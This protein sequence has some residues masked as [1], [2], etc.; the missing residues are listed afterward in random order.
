MP[1]SFSKEFPKL[2]LLCFELIT[3]QYSVCNTDEKT[4]TIKNKMKNKI[5]VIISLFALLSCAEAPDNSI[6]EINAAGDAGQTSAVYSVLFGGTQVGS[7]T[8]TT[9]GNQLSIDYGFEN[10]G[11]GASSVEQLTLSETGFPIEWQINGKTTF[12]NNVD[13]YFALNGDS[14]KWRSAAGSGEAENAANQMY[15]AQNGSPY[16]AYLYVNALIQSPEGEVAALPA[17]TIR[18]SDVADFTFENEDGNRP[19]RV[20]AL[21]GIDLDPTYLALDQNDDLMALLSPRFSMIL[22]G[23]EE[24]DAKLRELATNL[25][26]SRFKEI[27]E[28][29]THNFDA[30]IRI[31]NVRLFDPESLS[32]TS[33]K[34]V[35]VENERIIEVA[36][37]MIEPNE[38]EIIIDGAGGTLV[39]G[40]YEMH[41][42]MSDNDA[43]LNVLAGVTSVRDTGNE[44][45][46][47]GKLVENIESG[48]L[49]GPR[50]T[51]SGFIEGRSDFS[52]ATG[53]I[54]TTQEEA[55]E[56]VKMYASMEGY[57][58]IKIYSSVNGKWVPAMAEE[59]R[60]HGLRVMGHVPAFSTVDEMIMAGYNEITHINQVMLSWVL[61]RSEDT[62][63]LFRITGMKRFADL[64]IS[65]DK[66][67]KTLD[68]MTEKNIAVDP[69]IVIHEFGLTARNGE[70]R[71]G[72]RDYIEHMPISVQRNA[73]V[74]LL[75]VADENEDKAYRAAFDKILEVLSLMHE[76]GIFIVPGTDLGGAFELH[77]EIELFTKIGMSPAEA[78]KRG[79]YDMANYLGYGDDLGS[80]EQGKLA[81]F[82][83]ISGDPTKDVKAIKTPSMVSFGG[84]FF[85]PSEVYPEFGITPFTEKPKVTVPATN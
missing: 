11:R 71:V 7:T 78:V 9:N 57:K 3:E 59:A 72:M 73:K 58:Q 23:Y 26:A 22:A 34:S 69:T 5:L 35:L 56:L 77:R 68:L 51:R 63:T 40:L 53:E 17:G 4:T 8:V 20:V 48:V 19:A 28:R 54:A 50:I 45:D 70:T 15:I 75:N 79:S 6:K 64:D 41:G 33:L 55:V 1:F 61:D 84:R 38:N 31:N 37:T 2:A 81:D 85:F 47:I 49:I 27:A 82:F 62:R 42:H 65:S 46:V 21:S 80:I 83:L 60:K 10:N 29:V 74:A 13:E 30:P 66:V 14:A 52:N 24:S 32:L 44:I 76:K 12:G 16:S 39:P 25:N 43:L 67:Q 18:L 36:Q